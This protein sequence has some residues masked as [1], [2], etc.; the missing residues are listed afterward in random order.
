MQSKSII[1]EICRLFR[2]IFTSYDGAIFWWWVSYWDK[3]G[4][5]SCIWYLKYTGFASQKNTH[6]K[7]CVFWYAGFVL[8]ISIIYSYY[9]DDCSDSCPGLD[10]DTETGYL[11]E[12]SGYGDDYYMDEDGELICRCHEC[13]MNPNYDYWEE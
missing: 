3:T 13:P 5:G 1:S 10:E 7:R 12:C 9:G 2:W 6:Q 8:F 11:Y 4:H